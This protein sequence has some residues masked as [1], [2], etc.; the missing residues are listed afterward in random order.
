M[1]GMNFGRLTFRDLTFARSK[2]TTTQGVIVAADETSVTLKL[3]AGFP[4]V[5]HPHLMLTSCSPHPHNPH[6]ILIILTS[7]HPHLILSQ[8]SEMLADR[9]GRIKQEQGLYL[10]R[11]RRTAH[12]GA[13]IVQNTSC[14]QSD[15]NMSGCP[16]PDTVNHQVHFTCGSD[17]SCPVGTQAICL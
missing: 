7:P 15:G 16:W 17:F 6:L 9:A 12:A 14:M 13:Q 10:R 11:Y 8:I 5:S 2:R 1:T 4:Q 3:D